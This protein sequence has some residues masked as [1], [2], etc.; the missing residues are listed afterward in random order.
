MPS[1]MQGSGVP[2]PQRAFGLKALIKIMCRKHL[3]LGGKWTVYILGLKSEQ[4][5]MRKEQG[6]LRSMHPVLGK[7]SYRRA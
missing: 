6:P 1:Q 4:I 2:G 7:G 5:S 3:E